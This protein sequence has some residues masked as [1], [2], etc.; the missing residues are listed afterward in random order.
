MHS[1][2][3]L[4]SLP[5]IA[6][7]LWLSSC[8]PENL[9]G[10]KKT[11]QQPAEQASGAP[12][13]WRMASIYPSSVPIIGS[14]GA[15]LTDLLREISA[16]SVD[17]QFYEPGILTPPLE[18]FD[19]ISYGA[20]EA[21]WSTSGYW[22]GKEPALQ[23]FS[24][25]PFGPSA[26]EYL[27]W[28]DYGGGRA[29]FE[30]LYAK[31][32]IFSLICGLTPPEA[33]GW[34]KKEIKTVED[35]QGLKIRFFGLG[36]QVLEKLGASPLLISGGEIYQALEL[37]AIDASEYAMPA[38]DVRMGFHEVA[39]YY[40]FP[41]WHQQSTF[42]ELMMNLDAWNALSTTQQSQIEASCSTNIRVS[43]AEGE[44]LQADALRQIRAKG[45]QIKIWPDPVLEALEEA[46]SEV[47][48]DLSAQD[49]AF[50]EAWDSLSDFRAAYKGWSDLG[51][52]KN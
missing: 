8:Y 23:L 21:G 9:T 18:I 5:F 3:F 20:I 25:V 46:W 30:R 48:A 49:P 11:A 43:L 6:A 27:A 41:G 35:L 2:S 37:G 45:V 22:A 44:A 10:D 12:V 36:G 15:R 16:G 31:H 52:I 14:T 42:F 32:N 34:F 17:F 24:A 13:T 26:A 19:A 29:M 51:Y 40:Y 4:R 1:F 33:S 39:G 50:K 7:C 47:A 28:Y 38:V